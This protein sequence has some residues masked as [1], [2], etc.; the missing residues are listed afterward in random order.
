MVFQTR[1]NSIVDKNL[2]KFTKNVLNFTS[3]VLKPS[4]NDPKLPEFLR[5]YPLSYLR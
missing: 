4:T 3:Y 1:N 5:F 2:L